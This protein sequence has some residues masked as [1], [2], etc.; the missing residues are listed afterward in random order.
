MSPTAES[1]T[2][3]AIGAVDDHAADHA[4]MVGPVAPPAGATRPPK[5]RVSYVIGAV[6]V[7]IG[8]LAV[9]RA[10]TTFFAQPPAQVIRASGRIEGR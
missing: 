1:P 3:A 5:R 10:W 6:V 9:A 2:T 4:G 7:A 8:A